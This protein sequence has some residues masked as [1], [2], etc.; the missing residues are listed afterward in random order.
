MW[1]STHIRLRHCHLLRGISNQV[2]YGSFRCKRLFTLNEF[3]TH[4]N[5][6]ILFSTHT[7]GPEACLNVFPHVCFRWVG[8]NGKFYI[9]CLEHR[10][11]SAVCLA[12]AVDQLVKEKAEVHLNV[13]VYELHPQLFIVL[14][15]PIV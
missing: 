5:F 15:Y 9:S 7:L 11:C 1:P 14:L 4:L 10:A 3:H 2:F 13:N 12:G 6:L 8:Q